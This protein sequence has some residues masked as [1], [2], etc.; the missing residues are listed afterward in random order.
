EIEAA[1]GRAC[2]WKTCRASIRARM[3]EEGALL[4]GD[5]SGHLIFKDRWYGFSDGSYAAARLLELL[6]QDSEHSGSRLDALPFACGTPELRA[7]TGAADPQRL[8]DALSHIGNFVGSDEFIQIDGLRV[9][10]ADG[11]GLVRASGSTSALV[12]RFE[13]DNLHALTR[14]QAEFRK[15]LRRVAPRLQL[16]F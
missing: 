1:G 9:E 5:T 13:A 3:D 12:F 10:Y 4:G 2:M 7:L 14:I 8:I 15:Q 11:F 16:P 6:S